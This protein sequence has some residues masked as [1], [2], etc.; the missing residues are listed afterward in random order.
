MQER[1]LSKARTLEK[2]IAK[3]QLFDGNLGFWRN[4]QDRRLTK[5]GA[6]EKESEAEGTATDQGA[7]SGAGA[8]GQTA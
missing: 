3:Q 1:Q 2:E 7:H 8:V 6:L 4:M 5:E